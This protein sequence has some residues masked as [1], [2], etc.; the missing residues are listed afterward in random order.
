MITGYSLFLLAA[1][2]ITALL[3][4]YTRWHRRQVASSATGITLLLIAITLYVGG[5]GMELINTDL[6]GM[7]FWR[8]IEYVGIAPIPPLLLIM[9]LGHIDLTRQ[10]LRQSSLSSPSFRR[11]PSYW[12]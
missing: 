8:M 7:L 4:T 11:S 9:V 5:Y 12:F 3:A 10:S 2:I 1:A 6:P